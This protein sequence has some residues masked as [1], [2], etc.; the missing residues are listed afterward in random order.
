MSAQH[1]PKD[2]ALE[3]AEFRVRQAGEWLGLE[4]GLISELGRGTRFILQVPIASSEG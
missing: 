1:L 2:L 3:S 4:D